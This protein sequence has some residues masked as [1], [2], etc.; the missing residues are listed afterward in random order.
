MHFLQTE[1]SPQKVKKSTICLVAQRNL[2]RTCTG[3]A[4]KVHAKISN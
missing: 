3:E 1:Y 2:L 4:K